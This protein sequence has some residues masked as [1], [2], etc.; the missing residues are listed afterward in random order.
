MCRPTEEL[1]L[2]GQKSKL[3]EHYDILGQEYYE[4]VNK[5]E[6]D[7]N[8]YWNQ[9]K[10][11]DKTEIKLDINIFNMI[12]E[13]MPKDWKNANEQLYS[14]LFNKG[15]SSRGLFAGLKKS[16]TSRMMSQLNDIRKKTTI[17]ELMSSKYFNLFQKIKMVE[18]DENVPF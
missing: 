9:P 11:S 16:H 15:I 7:F 6:I 13:K 5:R 10:R 1:K 4:E 3:T 14:D 18:L 2:D 17:Q 8:A 12:Y